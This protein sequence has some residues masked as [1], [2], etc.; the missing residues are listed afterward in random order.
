[1]IKNFA[2]QLTIC[3]ASAFYPA[4]ST[5]TSVHHDINTEHE[6]TLPAVVAKGVIDRSDA[7]G[8]YEIKIS[9]NVELVFRRKREFKEFENRMDNA[10]QNI[11]EKHGG[12]EVPEWLRH[13]SFL[14]NEVTGIPA[15]MFI[16]LSYAE[17]NFEC[18]N[19][20]SSTAGGCYHLLRDSIYHKISELEGTQWESVFTVASLI[21]KNSTY[22][23]GRK[24]YRI[25]DPVTGEEDNPRTKT[26]YK[27]KVWGNS[28]LEGVLAA[29][30]IKDKVDPIQKA[31]LPLTPLNTYAPWFY[32]ES[33][34]KRFT[35]FRKTDPNKEILHIYGSQF[36]VALQ[37]GK[38]AIL[39]FENRNLYFRKDFAT[40]LE[41]EL[42]AWLEQTTEENG[43]APSYT[44][45]IQQY[46]E[47]ALS[48]LNEEQAQEQFK[49]VEQMATY[50]KKSKKFTDE[51]YEI[52][53]GNT[54]LLSNIRINGMILITTAEM[55]RISENME[56]QAMFES[57]DY[58]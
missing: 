50:F 23:D 46:K 54:A 56:Q 17:S 48:H 39:N 18:K 25:V 38:S 7:I 5:N 8:T 24:R 35:K 14:L 6:N 49:S 2:K 45:K 16:E 41:T 44:E 36:N 10:L 42:N 55:D 47:I 37:R 20:R 26:Y 1:M 34:G 3:L 51:I 29:E 57:P 33:P 19:N 4:S 43:T 32:G 12:A 9:D 28:F 58:E 27:D 30:L 40:Q 21:D 13:E 11:P 15:Q 53:E 31:K 52:A 22:K